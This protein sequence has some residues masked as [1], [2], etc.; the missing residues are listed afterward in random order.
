M[1][2]KNVQYS[3]WSNGTFQLTNNGKIGTTPARQAAAE[4]TKS[5]LKIVDNSS[6][7]ISIIH[8]RSAAEARRIFVPTEQPIIIGT[9]RHT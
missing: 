1:P 3:D 7:A 5:G 6:R 4:I 9:K 2:D 8:P